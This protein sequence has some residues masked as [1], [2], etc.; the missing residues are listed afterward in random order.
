C[1][2]VARRRRSDVPGAAVA[3][4][5]GRRVRDPLLLSPAPRRAAFRPLGGVVVVRHRP[6]DERGG[7]VLRR[8]AGDDR[9]GRGDRPVGGRR[10]YRPAPPRGPGRGG[11]LDPPRWGAGVRGRGRRRDVADPRVA[12]AAAVGGGGGRRGG[13]LEL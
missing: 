5:D 11:R 1:A 10:K 6:R 8:G 4:A 13:L 9:R 12:G 2:T 3:D 7:L